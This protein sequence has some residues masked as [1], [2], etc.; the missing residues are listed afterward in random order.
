MGAKGLAPIG[1][2][3]GY[4]LGN[5]ASDL[6]GMHGVA[7]AQRTN[8][9]QAALTDSTGGTAA[10]TFAAITAGTTYAQADIVA[11]KNALSQVVVSF[12]ELRTVLVNKGIMKGS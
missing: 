4:T 2:S 1:D 7:V 6:A 8:A 12:N 3:D 5:S 10:T 9:N 11:I